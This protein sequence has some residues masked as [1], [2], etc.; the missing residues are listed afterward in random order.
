VTSAHTGIGT[1]VNEALKEAEGERRKAQMRRVEM[2][3]ASAAEV[4]AILQQARTEADT[5]SRR[6]YEYQRLRKDNP[7]IL[8][9]IWWDE[10]SRVFFQ[11]KARGRIDLLD[12]HLTGDGLDITIFAPQPKTKP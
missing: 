3:R 10:M 1:K 8:A 2:E 6:L 12:K 5:F 4:N 7:D 11:L 9:A